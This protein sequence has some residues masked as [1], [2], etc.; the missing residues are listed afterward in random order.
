MGKTVIKAVDIL[1]KSGFFWGCLIWERTMQT[2]RKVN[3]F[4]GANSKDSI[5]ES[6]HNNSL[7]VFM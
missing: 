7:P 1:L 5:K 2:K 3:T 6:Q 4:S